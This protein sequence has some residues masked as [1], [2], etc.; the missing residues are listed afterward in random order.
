MGRAFITDVHRYPA[1]FRSLRAFQR[2]FKGA[3]VVQVGDEPIFSALDFDRVQATLLHSGQSS[4]PI[5]LAPDRLVAFDPNSS[6]NMVLRPRDLHRITALLS[7]SGEDMP[8]TVYSNAI[9]AIA[10]GMDFV[11]GMDYVIQRLQ[12]EDMT[13]EERI[14]KRFTRRN[15]KRLSNWHAYETSA[16]LHRAQRIQ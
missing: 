2:K 12:T 11:D 4:I 14:L 7:L 10:D 13:D 8:S 1:S 3:Y 9:A 6:H 15:L 16:A 5:T